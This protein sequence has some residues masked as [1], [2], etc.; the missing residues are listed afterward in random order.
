MTPFRLEMNEEQALLERFLRYVQVDTQSD[1]DASCSPSTEKQKDLARLLVD[2]L[3]ALGCADAAM[4]AW[5]Y[6]TA[7]VP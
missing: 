7:T 2:E 5:G 1:D 4:D 6:V 3:K